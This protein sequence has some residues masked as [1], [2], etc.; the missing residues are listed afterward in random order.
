MREQKNLIRKSKL[1]MLILAVTATLIAFPVAAQTGSITLP[2]RKISA[3]E[4]FENIQRQTGYKVA[5]NSSL[6]ESLSV[7]VKKSPVTVKAALDQLLAGSN[8]SY[9][10]DG[11]FIIITQ[12]AAARTINSVVTV[13][14]DRNIA[15]TVTGADGNP[16]EGVTVQL[17]GTNGK[18]AM[19]FV[20]GRFQITG[21]PSGNHILKLTSADGETVRFREVKVATGKDADVELVMSGEL[22]ERSYYVAE[23]ENTAAATKTTAYFVP[24]RAD[25]TVRAFSDEPKTEYSFIPY[26]RMNKLYMPKFGIKTNLLTWA[27]TTPNAAL[28]F[29]LAKKWTLDITA[30]YNPFQLEAGGINLLWYVQPELRYWFCQRFEKHFIGLHGIYGQYNIGDVDFLT[31]TFQDYRYKGWGAGAGI[32]YGYHLPMAKRWAWEFT[33]GMGYVYLQYDKYRC[34]ECDEYLGKKGKHY[35]GPTKAGISLIYMIK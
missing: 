13:N 12:N 2:D 15:G 14:T 19:T 20:N 22:V 9:L 5:V 34:Y 23:A 10:A 33:V 31:T 16:I 3:L 32:S 11:R 21:V 27:T 4:V 25:N 8:L 30:A 1:K 26:D 18:T 24:N 29:S 6:T 17:M 35:F 28:E 7:H